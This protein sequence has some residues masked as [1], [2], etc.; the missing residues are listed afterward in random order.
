MAA[1]QGQAV[2]PLREALRACHIP[3]R[4][5]P[6]PVVRETLADLSQ[7]AAR[8]GLAHGIAHEI[9]GRRARDLDVAA[10][11]SGA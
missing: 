2:G 8:H 10:I 6:E 11:L 1:L 3:L 4:N 5:I 7:Y 9:T